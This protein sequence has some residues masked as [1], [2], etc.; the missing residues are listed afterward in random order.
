MNIKSPPV[1]TPGGLLNTV[2]AIVLPILSQ[3]LSHFWKLHVSLFKSSCL[4]FSRHSRPT[5]HVL[6]ASSLQLNPLYSI[7][8]AHGKPLFLFCSAL[9]PLPSSPQWNSRSPASGIPAL[10]THP[11]NR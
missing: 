6:F 3:F 4:T 11:S 2:D 8:E 9:Q 1:S 7:D 5:P 10:D